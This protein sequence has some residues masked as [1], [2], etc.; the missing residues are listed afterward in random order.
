MRILVV[1]DTFFPK[2]DGI[3]TSVFNS[4]KYLGEKGHHVVVLAPRY[5]N[6]K[7]E[8]NLTNVT[9][10][11]FKSFAFPTYKDIK[12][13]LPGVRKINQIFNSFQPNIVHVHTF[14]PI[15]L[16]SMV[17]AKLNKKPL[18]STY[19][20]F[21][22]DTLIYLSPRKLLGVEKIIDYLK[23]KRGTKKITFQILPEI[24]ENIEKVKKRLA[25]LTKRK[26]R[27]NN[28]RENFQLKAVWGITKL[29]YNSQDMVIAPSKAIKKELKKH[30]IPKVKIISNGM[31]LDLFLPKKKYGEKP[32][33]LHIGR[34]GFEKRINIVIDAMAEVVKKYP[35][36]RLSIVGDGPAKKSLKEQVKK[37]GLRDNI[38]FYGFIERIKL[39]EIYREHDVFVTASEMETQGLV[40]IEALAS[41]LPI[42]GVDALAIPDVVHQ[43]RTG[44]IARK[45]DYIK[46]AGY[47][48]RF[49]EQPGLAKKLGKNARA[50]AKKHE[51]KKC[52]ARLEKTYIEIIEKW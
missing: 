3:S 50:E 8:V 17:L 14:G 34:I 23:K 33:F 1:A 36:A 37:L 39:P 15:C 29:L 48:M 46:I 2:I 20:T 28:E 11:R 9:I 44:F 52:L 6:L 32:L 21:L 4:V 18:V 27:K 43:G 24:R 19:H 22:P 5:E 7:E 49:L 16:L 12:V 45:R 42:I 38:V 31:E 25:Y 10:Y 30:S 26:I 51:I 40:L 41:G 13:P 35:Y 47:M